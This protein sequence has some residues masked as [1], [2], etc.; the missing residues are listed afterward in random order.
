MI[1]VYDMDK[2]LRPF[3]KKKISENSLLVY[4][5]NSKDELL[6]IISTR[7]TEYEKIFINK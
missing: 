2:S 3:L 1:A 6:D 4:E 5:I 7:L